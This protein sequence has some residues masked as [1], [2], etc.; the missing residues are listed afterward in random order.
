MS[1]DLTFEIA[2][3]KFVP[4]N[5]DDIGISLDWRGDAREAELSTETIILENKAKQLVLDHIDNIG[6]LEGIPV[7]VQIGSLSIDYQINL[8]K[9]PLI[10]GEGD[11]SISVNIEK[12]NATDWFMSQ[13]EPL[14]FEAINKINPITTFNVPYLIVKD[15]QLELLITLSISTYQ[16]TKALIEGIRDL[17]E[18]I[19]EITQASTPNTGVPPSVDTGDI[20]A[21]VL[22][23]VARTAYVIA[24][25]IA[26]I[27]ITKQI[28]EL[29]FPPVR[30][31]KASSIKELMIKG[32]S[33][34]GNGYQF[35]STILD[36][37]PQLAVLPVPLVRQN[38][39]IFTNL[40]TLDN[41]TYNKGYPT[42][43]DTVSKLG[44]LIDALENM[45]NAK[46]RVINNTVFLER[47]DY[48]QLTSS[49]TVTTTLNLQ[50][51]REN[52]WT[53]D[54][55]AIWR[56]Y[57]LH[58]RTDSSDTNTVDN[59]EGSDC[60]YLTVPDNVVNPDLV[61]I[62]GNVDIDIPFALASRKEK[63]TIVEE[64]T[65]PFAELADEVVQFFGG[66][67]SLTSKIQGRVGVMQISQ[68][69]FDVTKIIYS[70]SGK[71]PNNYRQKI[72]ANRW[73]QDFHAINE[74]DANF[75][76]I[77]NNSVKFSES[78]FEALL[79]NN[80][81]VDQTGNSL[82]IST[83]DWLKGDS[84][85]DITYKQKSNEG[86]NTRTIAINT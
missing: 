18:A 52:Q 60:E 59:I 34:I 12:R 25:T 70:V 47:R 76:R 65:L 50:E 51:E 13:A 68:Q 58:F 63:L 38:K 82:E 83:F 30:N 2:G 81:L 55:E 8:T 45:F 40:F 74:V 79:N 22:K 27:A 75:K 84:F 71:Q 62:T 86:F 14:S 31:F 53:Y 9:N 28:I 33:S 11:S 5:I 37:L 32:C 16:L 78:Q 64:A 56:R 23:A 67:S 35:S 54:T 69:H 7:N 3:T 6:A 20:I 42:A 48:W 21:A 1:L 19:A 80:Y 44:E 46:V 73:Y 72:A 39:S 36:S 29:I 10:S 43:K 85:A 41:G 66:N 57:Y 17:V 49:S 24:I 26:L 61:N 77:Y 15:N 4:K